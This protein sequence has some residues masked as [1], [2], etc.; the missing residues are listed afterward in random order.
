MGRDVHK[1]HLILILKCKRKKLESKSN[2]LTPNNGIIKSFF[3]TNI[4][5]VHFKEGRKLSDK[6]NKEKAN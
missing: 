6:R 1:N 4:K 5:C 3:S 2:F